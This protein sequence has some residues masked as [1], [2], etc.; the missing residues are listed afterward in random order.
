MFSENNDEAVTVA[1]I[2]TANFQCRDEMSSEVWQV[3]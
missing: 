1:Q 3:R 2:S